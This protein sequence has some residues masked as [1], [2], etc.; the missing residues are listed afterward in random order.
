M[1]LI[2]TYIVHRMPVMYPSKASVIYTIT[3]TAGGTVESLS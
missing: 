2:S 1:L 3:R